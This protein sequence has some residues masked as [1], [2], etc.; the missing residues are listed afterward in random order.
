MCIAMQLSWDV[1][2]L[3]ASLSVCTVK[4]VRQ[5]VYAAILSHAES[6]MASLRTCHV[7][8]ELDNTGCAVDFHS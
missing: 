1:L 5:I 4:T 3:T 2:S 8:E 7:K 6:L